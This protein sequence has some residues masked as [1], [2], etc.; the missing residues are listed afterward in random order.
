MKSKTYDHYALIVSHLNYIYSK[1]EDQNLKKNTLKDIKN[2]I[3]SNPYKARILSKYITSYFILMEENR[4]LKTGRL[5][6]QLDEI[7]LS[8]KIYQILA[9]PNKDL[10][11]EEILNESPTNPNRMMAFNYKKQI[12][13][14]NKLVLANH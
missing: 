13:S 7:E 8:E 11:I 9:L 10:K 5:K 4:N 12:D 1:E 14:L 3:R 6:L 2:N